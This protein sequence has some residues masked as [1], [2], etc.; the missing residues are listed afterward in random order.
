MRVGRVFKDRMRTSTEGELKAMVNGLH[1]AIRHFDP[2]EG[3]LVVAQTDCAYTAR[4]LR[5]EKSNYG[6][7]VQEWKRLA[8]GRGLKVRLRHVKGHQGYHDPRSAVNEWAHAEAIRLMREE[9]DRWKTAG[10]MRHDTPQ[11]DA[12]RS[13]SADVSS[14]YRKAEGQCDDRERDAAL[15]EGTLGVAA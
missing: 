15:D 1:Q 8:S 6:H 11:L 2:A 13:V 10:V 14:P 4:T 3:L 5:G 9:R 7:I 12:G